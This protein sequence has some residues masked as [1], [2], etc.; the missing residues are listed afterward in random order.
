MK[1]A[2]KKRHD[3]RNRHIRPGERVV[4]MDGALWPRLPHE[5]DESASS[6]VVGR[7]RKVIEQ[8]RR[9]VEAGIKDDDVAA[10]MDALYERD[11]RR[12]H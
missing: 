2:S 8:A 3:P 1:V 4:T 7:P 6:Q 9:D 11:F 12:R 10:P 5:R